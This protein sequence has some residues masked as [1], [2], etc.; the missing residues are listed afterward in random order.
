MAATLDNITRAIR[1]IEP[2]TY[3]NIFGPAIDGSIV[4]NDPQHNLKEHGDLF[5]ELDLL[6]GVTKNEAFQLLGNQE[7][8]HGI[9][10]EK[11]DE[12][13]RTLVQNLFRFH[14]NEIFAA[15]SDEYTDWHSPLLQKDDIRNA[16][17]KALG[18]GL[19]VAPVVNAARIHARP[20]RPFNGDDMI[21]Y[22]K[23]LL[24]VPLLRLQR[25]GVRSIPTFLT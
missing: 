20:K 13:Y 12:I 11:R 24:F 2:P 19:Y 23:A 25:C 9:T 5:R 6:V 17:L 4:A 3:L 10:R 8:T 21:N 15:I 22:G 18:D 16:V 14:R 1:D 7:L